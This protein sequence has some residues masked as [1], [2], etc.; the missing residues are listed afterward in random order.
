MA[1]DRR[2][3]RI[4]WQT[5]RN[6]NGAED[7]FRSRTPL[8]ITADGREQLISAG[9]GV[10]MSLD[11][12]PVRKSGVKYGSGYSVVPRPVYSNGLVYLCSGYDS[13]V[14]YAIQARRKGD[15][16][17]THVAVDGEERHSPQML[18]HSWWTTRSILPPMT[19]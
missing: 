3:G 10:V 17:N 2:T 13:P 5:P 18:R 1:L 19:A 11:P 6:M 16:T 14:F 12:R 7:R 9:S 4:A 15:V 8:V